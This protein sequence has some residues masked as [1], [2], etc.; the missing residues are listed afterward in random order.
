MSRCFIAIDLDHALKE[1]ILEIQGKINEPSLKI[2]EKQNIHITLKFLGE[3]SENKIQD[4]IK[5]V[6]EI[7]LHKF[8]LEIQGMGAFPSINY[9]R[10][11]WLGVRDDT[12]L[13]ELAKAVDDK[14]F[15]F[16]HEDFS[17]HLTIARVKLR[18][19]RLR[20]VILQNKDIYIGKQH[21]DRF[22]LK[23]SILLS[24]GPVY[25]D[26]AVFELI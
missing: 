21:V 7:N 11:V 26:L 18:P 13:V 25:E 14:L 23:K 15:D 10:V 2:V 12:R 17:A 6:K 1:H 24:T 5:R 22:V 3:V 19:T 8:D 9:M 4:V 20:E 16:K